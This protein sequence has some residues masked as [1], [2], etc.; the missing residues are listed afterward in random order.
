MPS[1]RC[2]GPTF[3]PRTARSQARL[4]SL[5]IDLKRRKLEVH[6]PVLIRGS[7]MER[8]SNFKFLGVIISDDLSWAQHVIRRLYLS[9]LDSK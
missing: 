2:A 9:K 4:R 8:V 5:I 3:S 6:K 1:C 7:E